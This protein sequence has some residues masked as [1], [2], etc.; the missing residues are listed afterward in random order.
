MSAAGDIARQLALRVDA[1]VLDL[2]PAGHREGHEWR[3]GSIAGEAGDSL[4]VRLVGHKRGVWADFSADQKGDALNLVCAVHGFSVPA[5]IQWSRRWL[6][7]D[8]GEAAPPPQRPSETPDPGS[9][10]NNSGDYWRKHWR[11]ARYI[12]GGLAETYLHR[13]GLHF[14]EAHGRVLRFAPSHPRRNVDDQLERSPALLALLRDI[15]TGEPCG[16]VNI[17]LQPDGRDRLRDR[18]AKTCWG[19]A[20]GSAVMLSGFDEPTYGLTVCEGTETGIR[21]LAA[22]LAPVWA[23]GGA[24]NLAGFPVLSGIEALT[25]AADADPPGQK[26]AQAVAQRWRE[27]QREAVIIAPPHGDWADGVR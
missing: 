11:Q 23:L 17:Y 12:G 20:A 4:G 25:V 27:A 14:A 26:A 10:S 13:R 24:G 6:G 5:A 9:A 16:M 7:I 19:R 21:L 3:C 22:D 2:L 18:K 1:L 8:N 15:H